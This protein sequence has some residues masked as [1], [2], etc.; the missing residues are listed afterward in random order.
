LPHELGEYIVADPQIRHGKPTFKGTRVMVFQVL[1]QVACGMTTFFR[2]STA[3]SA[4]LS[5]HTPN[6]WAK[7][8]ASIRRD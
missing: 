3:S 4:R 1:E 6:A 5:S 2:Y 8:F 7:L